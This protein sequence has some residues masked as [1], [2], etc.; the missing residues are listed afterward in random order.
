MS[1]CYTWYVIPP[2]RSSGLK[3]LGLMSDVETLLA[4]DEHFLLGRWLEDAKT[5]ATNDAEKQLYEYNA[6]NQ[7]TLWGPTDGNV[8]VFL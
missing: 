4:S 5:Q 8:C 6:R 7:L 3:L 1:L 2:D